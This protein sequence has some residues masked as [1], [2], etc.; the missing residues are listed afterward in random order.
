MTRESSAPFRVVLIYAVFAALWILLSDMAVEWL[1]R[2]PADIVRASMIK[3][4]LFVAVTSLLLYVLVH[5]TWERLQDAHRRELAG[6]AEKRR[7][8]QLLDTIAES[9][10]DA[11]FAKDR[12]GRY[13]LFN[14]AASRIVGKPAAEILGRDDNTLFPAEQAEMLMAIDRRVMTDMCIETNEEVLETA[15]GTKVFLGT[16]GPLRDADGQI[17]GTYGISRDITER[18]QSELG[19]RREHDL[20]QRYLDTVQTIIVALDREARVTMINGTG[21]QMLGCTEKEL[22]GRNWFEICLP[23]PEGMAV[24]F[25][26]FKQIMAGNLKFAEYHENPILGRNGQQRMIA[27]RNSYLTDEAGNIVGT[28]SSGEDITERKQAEEELRQRNE[29]LERFNRATIGRELDMIELKKHINALSKELGREPLYPLD[30]LR[31]ESQ[32]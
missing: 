7:A 9:S 14:K 32:S 20:K 4:W 23:Q 1:F 25:P 3:G 26:L 15:H 28:L 31:D 13:I 22:I 10:L 16:K 2:D 24:V 11:I 8:L 18:K 5:R 27:W 6:E 12:E 21:C 19:L 30:F 17:I 29:E